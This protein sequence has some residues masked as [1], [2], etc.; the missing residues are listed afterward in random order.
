MQ[1]WIWTHCT[2]L[3]ALICEGSASACDDSLPPFRFYLSCEYV[4]SISPFWLY[5]DGGSLLC[6]F[7]IATRWETVTWLLSDQRCFGG[8][9]RVWEILWMDLLNHGTSSAHVALVYKLLIF[10]S[11][12]CLLVVF[13]IWQHIPRHLQVQLLE[14]NTVGR[15]Q[16]HKN[17][18]SSPISVLEPKS[19]ELHKVSHKPTVILTNVRVL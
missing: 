5:M 16:N 15:H 9:L 14:Q 7:Q 12:C 18:V 6:L 4:S 11:P 10:S 3:H 2:L 1:L 8:C 19:E 17:E 13:A